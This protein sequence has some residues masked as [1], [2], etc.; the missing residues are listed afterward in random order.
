MK[1]AN[2][3]IAIGEVSSGGVTLGTA[4]GA[5]EIGIKEGSAAWVDAKTQFGRVHNRLQATVA[6]GESEGEVA[7]QARTSFGDIYID[8]SSIT[9]EQGEK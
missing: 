7:V 2:G 1:T 3:N 8:R 5:L 9:Q 4:S 6:P